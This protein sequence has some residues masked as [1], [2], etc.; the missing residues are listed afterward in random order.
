MAKYL[1]EILAVVAVLAFCGIFLYTSSTMTSAEFAGSDNVGSNLI[2]ELSGKPVES[3]VPLI[4]QW[5]PPSG[6]IEACLFA[7][8]AAVG[9][10]FV[11]GVFGYW[12]GQKKSLTETKVH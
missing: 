5:Q 11:G 12:L 3:F 8:Q 9:G 2:A 1:L 4:P 7:L 6:E 10:I